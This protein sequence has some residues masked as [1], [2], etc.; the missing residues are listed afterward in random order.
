[1]RSRDIDK[2]RQDHQCVS[3]GQWHLHLHMW[4]P[5][6]HSYANNKGCVLED[7]TVTLH[8]EI[9]KPGVPVE[10]LKGGE[11]LREGQ[12]H[13]MRQEGRT[14]ELVIRSVVLQDAGEYSCVVN[15]YGVT[16]YNGNITVGQTQKTPF[17]AKSTTDTAQTS[18]P[19]VH[20][21]P[22]SIALPLYYI[23]INYASS[24]TLSQVSSPSDY[25]TAPDFIEPVEIV[26]KDQHRSDCY[27]VL[28]KCVQCF[29][30]I[31]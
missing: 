6:N 13:Q 11:L 10:W 14:S 8:C 31:L 27:N 25:D 12:K 30:T 24:F 22:A 18:T 3:G 23:I 1:K 21:V 20:P 9:S 26:T 29:I 15:K 4:G 2:C 28:L 16:S 7:G 19:A 5:E 17:S